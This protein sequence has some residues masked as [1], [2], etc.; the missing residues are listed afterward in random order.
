MEKFIHENVLFAILVRKD[1][2]REGVSFVTDGT[3]LLEMGYMSHPAGHA[4]SGQGGHGR[5]RR[6]ASLA[7]PA[8][9][10]RPDGHKLSDLN[11][12]Y[13]ANQTLLRERA[14]TF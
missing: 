3:G 1:F 12:E 14:L 8:A 6:S 10:A 5:P 9:Q 11:P 2:H 13:P 7:G 4:R